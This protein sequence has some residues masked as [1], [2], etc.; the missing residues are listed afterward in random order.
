[1]AWASLLLGGL[2]AGKSWSRRRA[3]GLLLER[4]RDLDDIRAMSWQDFERLVGEC[5]RR[6]GYRVVETGQGGADGGVDLLLR[7][8]SE[9][10]LVQCK[11]WRKSSV[12]APVV[13]E[14]L[15][16]LTHHAADRVKIVS[17]GSFTRDA[18]A[19]A[20]GKPID[21]LGGDDLLALVRQVQGR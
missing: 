4:Q 19:F 20:K 2:I 21:L 14:M 13:R 7:R 5:F 12:G 10:V 8:G 9:K 18:V 16:L 3:R 1:M 17:C 6:Y 15:G 11:Q